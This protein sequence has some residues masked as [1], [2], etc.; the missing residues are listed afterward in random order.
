M[1]IM[2]IIAFVYPDKIR[3]WILK[4]IGRERARFNL[5]DSRLSIRSSGLM[6]ILM[7]LFVLFGLWKFY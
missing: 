7:G 2:G 3:S 5:L 1:L 6:G 4:I